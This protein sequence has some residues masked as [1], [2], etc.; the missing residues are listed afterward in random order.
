MVNQSPAKQILLLK[1][2]GKCMVNGSV[3]EELLKL[4]IK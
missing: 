4:L 2:P 3:L 1:L